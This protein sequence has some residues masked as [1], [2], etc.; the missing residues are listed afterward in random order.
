MTLGRG[1]SQD[2]KSEIAQPNQDPLDSIAIEVNNEA[3]YFF[4]RGQS[5]MH[6]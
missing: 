4:S 2:F 3:M 6:G 1:V 5:A